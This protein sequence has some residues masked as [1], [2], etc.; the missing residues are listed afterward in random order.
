MDERTTKALDASIL[1]WTEMSNGIGM[2]RTS[3]G[4]CALCELFYGTWSCNG[5]P[6]MARTGNPFCRGTP[7]SKYRHGQDRYV[8]QEELMQL[9]KEEVDFLTSLRPPL[10]GGGEGRDAEAHTQV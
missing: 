4:D 7:Y 2:E 6:V 5:C 8:P 3:V 1:K 9:A 10:M